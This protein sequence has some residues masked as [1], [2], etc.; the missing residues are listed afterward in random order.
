MKVSWDQGPDD[1]L[2]SPQY[3]GDLCNCA[4]RILRDYFS[5]ISQKL[6][7]FEASELPSSG[8]RLGR[9]WAVNHRANLTNAFP[10]KPEPKTDL[11]KSLSFGSHCDNLGITFGVVFPRHA[12][13]HIASLFESVPSI[14][15]ETLA[16]VTTRR[17][18]TGRQSPTAGDGDVLANT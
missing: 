12:P 14:E 15:L 2:R 11:R 16:E 7:L 5:D 3:G 13:Q 1:L 4:S 8:Q 10:S 18:P 17:S 6:R 9:G